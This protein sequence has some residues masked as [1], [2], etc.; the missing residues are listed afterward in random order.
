MSMARSILPAF[1]ATILALAA[2]PVLAQKTPQLMPTWPLMDAV[3]AGDVEKAK[4]T[5][6]DGETSA[7]QADASDRTVLMYAAGSGDAAMVRLLLDAGAR[8]ILTDKRG[9][10]AL[11]AAAENGYDEVMAM[12]MAAG[13]RPDADDRTGV[14]PLMLAVSA[15]CVPCVR[16]L[17]AAR[18]DPDRGDL[19]GRNARERA[20][21][22]RN[23]TVQRML[24]EAPR[25]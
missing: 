14:T 12:L 24:D 18:A 3:K 8:P 2:G 25:R 6:L 9:Y 19:G 21:F 10:T 22:Q 17:L 4:K 13:A 11:H 16:M 20:A 15:S 1:L 7:N 23:R 5:L